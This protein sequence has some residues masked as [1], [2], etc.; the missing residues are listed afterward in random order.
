[1][2]GFAIPLILSG[3]IASLAV[4]AAIASP[5]NLTGS[6]SV[7]QTGYNGTTT[8]SI[9]LTQSGNGVVGTNAANGNGFTGTFVTDGQIN[10]K[11]HGPG[12][13]AG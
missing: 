13:A 3:A 4:A 7:Q 8:S 5:P 2:K 12:G 11:W 6:W 10:G 9:T 1:M